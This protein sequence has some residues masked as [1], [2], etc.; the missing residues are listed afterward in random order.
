[1]VEAFLKD[2]MAD[3]SRY[4]AISSSA[5][6]IDTTNSANDGLFFGSLSQHLSRISYLSEHKSALKYYIKHHDIT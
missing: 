2:V 6:V 3:R 5:E 1:M 4:P